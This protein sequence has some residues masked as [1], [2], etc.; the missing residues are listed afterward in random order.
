MR[1]GSSALR[2]IA[3]ALVLAACAPPAP[4]LAVPPSLLP[5][6][7]GTWT[8]TWGGTALTL[9][10]L[11]QQQ[12][13]PADGVFLGPWQ[14]LGHQL[15]SVSGVLTYAVR[16]EPVSVNVQ[17]RL[18]D[19]NGRL[20]LV[21]DQVSVNGGQLTL[22]LTDPNR[23]IGTGASRATWEPQGLVELVRQTTSGPRG[24]IESGYAAVPR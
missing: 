7:R 1:L 23:L 17:G 11:D 9:V 6:L 19:M 15:P 2:A 24:S 8:G 16:G 20:T 14:L 4:P 13:T 5:D 3:C 22:A 12:A 18:G 21:I 10:V